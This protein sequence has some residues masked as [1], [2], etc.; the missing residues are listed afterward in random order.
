MTQN[1]RLSEFTIFDFKVLVAHTIAYFIFGLIM[2]NLLNYTQLFEQEIIR[3]F[4]RPIDSDY[5]LVGPLMQPVRGL[6]F[7]LGIWPIRKNILESKHGWLI[8]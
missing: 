1:F 6:F 7:S 5:V 3:D 4:M 2:S 8:L